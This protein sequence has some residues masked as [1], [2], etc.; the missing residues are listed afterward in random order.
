MLRREITSVDSGRYEPIIHH[1]G[2]LLFLYI[3]A[4]S[5]IN[6]TDEFVAT[7]QTLDPDVVGVAE[8]WANSNILDAEIELE[9][10]KMFRQDRPTDKRGGGVLLYVRNDLDAVEYLPKTEYPEHKWCRIKDSNKEELNIG[11]CYRTG[12]DEIFGLSNH[13]H[14]RELVSEFSNKRTILMGDF[15]YK[16]LNWSSRMDDIGGVPSVEGRLFQECIE[17]NFFTQHVLEPTRDGNILDLVISSHPDLVSNVQVIS[18]LKNSDHNMILYDVHMGSLVS[19]RRR[20]QYNYSKADFDSI[21]TELGCLN[22][23]GLLTGDTESCWTA[24]KDILRSLENKHIPFSVTRSTKRKALWMTHRARKLVAKKRK[25]FAKYK[26]RSHPAVVKVNKDTT[27]A[28][29]EAK[30]NFESKLAD[31]IKNDTK[32]FFAYARC[33]NKSKVTPGPLVNKEGKDVDSLQGIAEEFNNYFASVFSAEQPNGVE[34]SCGVEKDN[35][36][37][38]LMNIEFSEEDIKKK[39]LKVRADKAPGDDEIMPRLI[40]QIS[41]EI[42]RPLWII[43]RKSMDEGI[44]PKDWKTA[45]V[46]PLFKNG[47]RNKAEN[48]RPVSLTSQ[49]SKVF[50]SLIRDVMVKHLENYQLLLDSQHGFRKG[51]SCLTNLLT[52]MEKVTK[53]LDEGEDLDIVF[54]DFAKAFDKVPH[55][56]L[57]QKL[58]THGICGKLGHWIESWLSDR[59]QR[60]CIGGTKSKWIK[61]LSGVPQGS[62][63]G[64]ILFL[65]FINDLDTGVMSWILKFADDTK[66]YRKIRTE[67]DRKL[68]QKD[69]DT[70]VKW[71]EDW[72]MLFN[73]K[74]CKSMHIGNGKSQ[75]AYTVNGHIIENVEQE[76]DLGMIISRDM[77]VWGQ[78]NYAYVKANRMLGLIKRTIKFKRTDIMLRL[79]KALVRPHLEYCSEVWSPYYKKDKEHL[80]KIQHRFTRIIPGLKDM[81]YNERLKIL[82]LWTL[83][84]RRNRADL[85]ET[86]KLIKG[87]SAVPYQLFFELDKNSR[88]RGHCYRIVKNRFSKTVRQYSFSQRV[89]NRWNGLDQQ[90]VE[91]Q[92][93]N[94]F[95][96]RLS[97]LRVTKMGL[98]MD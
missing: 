90:T 7:V 31:N 78:C 13:M 24:F 25:V 81:T 83:E 45:N 65:I 8:S 51:R 19:Q 39:L 4:R 63:L 34:Q 43:F 96:S 27:K 46:T 9:G 53:C 61:V 30:L 98:F 66:I 14:L 26:D 36:I 97:K 82:G 52:L 77:K 5:V 6:K 21:R 38:N 69:L 92:T 64:P 60:T 59:Y 17:D 57:L 70:L 95:K 94:E 58:K 12:T 79:Y 89:I 18:C 50:E 44:V 91:S 75:Y 40:C 47:S 76:K 29:A 72:L 71:A 80:E 41:E 23:E 32:S 73:E 22:W 88:T 28:I 84:E 33:G 54:L 15:N 74:K 67:E 2:K 10:Y 37:S 85:I 3:N 56:R 20:I 86:F 35:G 16:G 55:R 42:S 11:I 49:I 68:L 87:L 62:V 1:K 93:L 48:Y